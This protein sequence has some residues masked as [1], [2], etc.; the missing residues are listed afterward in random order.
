MMK[1]KIAKG[2]TQFTAYFTTAVYLLAVPATFFLVG[3]DAL[4]P[5][6]TVACLTLSGFMFTKSAYTVRGL[7]KL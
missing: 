3:G 6:E 2:L 1:R 4:L 7:M 5:Y